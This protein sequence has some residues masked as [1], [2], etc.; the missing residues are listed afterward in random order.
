MPPRPETIQE[1]IANWDR[2][3]RARI[4]ENQRQTLRTRDAEARVKHVAGN[5]RAI[6]EHDQSEPVAVIIDQP[7]SANPIGATLP[8][9]SLA[10]GVLANLIAHSWEARG[11]WRWVD[12]RGGRKARRYFTLSATTGI[13]SRVY[14]V[15]QPHAF[16]PLKPLVRGARPERP[17]LDIEPADFD[18][19]LAA[20]ERRLLDAI[21]TDEAE[22]DTER[23]WLRVKTTKYE[24][25]FA[26]PGDYPTGINMRFRPTAAQISDAEDLLPLIARLPAKQQQAMRLAA[27]GFVP[28]SIAERMHTDAAKVRQYIKRGRAACWQWYAPGATGVRQYPGAHRP[29]RAA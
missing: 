23:K 24:S 11:Y 26:A 13:P 5:A 10:E 1:A 25:G 12:L 6:P 8:I 4:R 15:D 28:K 20:F 21:R 2:H 14:G 7:P 27:L 9:S 22:V 18:Q 3:T 16:K 19:V 17:A 29:R